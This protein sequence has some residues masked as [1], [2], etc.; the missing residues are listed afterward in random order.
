MIEPDRQ[1]PR[2][3]HHSLD[4][5]CMLS[6]QRCQRLR[7]GRALPAPDSLSISSDRDGCVFQRYVETDIFAHG[8]CPFDAEL[9]QHG[10]PILY[11]IGKQP[12]SVQQSHQRSALPRLP[13]IF[14]FLFRCASDPAIDAFVHEAFLPTPHSGLR[15]ARR[16]H[17][18]RSAKT[19]AAE[20]H[21]AG[22]PNMLLRAQR[23]RRYVAQSLAVG[24][25]QGESDTIAHPPRLAR[26]N[27]NGNPQ[28]D[29]LGGV[30]KLTH[31]QPD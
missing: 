31:P 28:S 15:L 29:S 20:Q 13:H 24:F 16:C 19:I 21:D 23:C 25:G 3:E 2:L 27:A 1:G 14:C 26:Q 18:G 12:H 22:S 9:A 4:R 7:I 10:E 30:D 5:R 11:A 6:N 8:C 17:N